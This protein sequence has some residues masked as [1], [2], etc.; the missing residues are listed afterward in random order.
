MSPLPVPTTGKPMGSRR[1]SLRLAVA[2]AL[3]VLLALVP[4]FS[5]ALGQSFYVTLVSRMMIFA[6]AATGLN[7]VMGYGAMVSFGHAL[8]IGLGAYAVGILSQHGI[9]NG[10]LHLAAALGAG[11]VL[12]T[13]IGLVCL[14]ARGVGF[15]MITLAFAQMFY[16][17]AVSLKQYGGDDGFSIGGRS[18][19]GVVDLN[20]NVVLYYVIFAALVAA[21]FLFYRLV[22]ARFG[23]VLKGCRTNERRLEALG[24]PVAR[25]K[26]AAYVLSALVCV[27]AGVL[28]ANLTRFVSPSYMH[29]VVS[30]DLIVMAVLGGLGTLIGPVVGAI[31]WLTLE[32][33]LS[34]F[35][36]GWAV[37][38][39]FVRNHWLGVLGLMALLVALRLKDGI[40]GILVA[41]EQGDR[42]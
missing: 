6:L 14:R 32:D 15:I 37:L 5:H 18:D 33:L 19:F 9:G 16:F 1:P 34:S 28:L 2:G 31:L 8:Y 25:V 26:L 11:A 7:L 13:L 12:A 35:N 29:W 30:G 36:L 42:P 39:D 3:L 23:M 38:D 27:L 40:Y 24:M 17:L 10:W 4:V 22:H 41:R 21:L 20:D